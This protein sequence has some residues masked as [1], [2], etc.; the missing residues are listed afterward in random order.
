MIQLLRQILGKGVSHQ[1]LYLKMQSNAI[2]SLIIDY[3]YWYA[4]FHY[5]KCESMIL[6]M[7]MNNE[8]FQMLVVHPPPSVNET[9]ELQKIIKK[10]EVIYLFCWEV[11]Q[12]LN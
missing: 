3:S 7:S 11:S 8:I 12:I 9:I 4:L 1:G 6:S 2:C 5:E 10:N